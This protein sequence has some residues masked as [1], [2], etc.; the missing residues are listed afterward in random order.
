MSEGSGK[1]YKLLMGIVMLM[2]VLTILSIVSGNSFIGYSAG[3]SYSAV[4][5]G[6]TVDYTI[7]S[8][9]FNI[10][11]YAGAIGWFF[12]IIGIGV[13]SGIAVLGSG[14]SDVSVNLLYK[15]IFYA[16]LWGI[17]SVFPIS[18]MFGI[19]L[20]GPL[21]YISLTIIYVISCLMVI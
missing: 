12:I 21:L 13:G 14:L 4:I 3:D 7:S 18:L 9:G 8:A 19:Y 20:F 1:N 16:A 2:L 11:A 6:T 15:A 17:L 10:D 5:N